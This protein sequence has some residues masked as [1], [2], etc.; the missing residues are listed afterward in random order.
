MNRLIKHIEREIAMPLRKQV[1]HRSGEIVTKALVQTEHVQMT[2]YALDKEER[3]AT[4]KI[5]GEIFV[6]IIEGTA[7][8]TIGEE[9][10]IV[11]GGEVIV[12]PNEKP[13]AV[14][15]L[16]S[17]KMLVVTIME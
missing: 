11:T 15:A 13:H 7:Q 6:Y 1:D 16:E 17:F 9:V 14:L 10:N 5:K 4:H 12:I 3:I 8:F 2:L